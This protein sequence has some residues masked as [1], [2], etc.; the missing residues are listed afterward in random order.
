MEE[1]SVSLAECF[2][3]DDIKDYLVDFSNLRYSF[4]PRETN[5]IAH[6]LARYA[7][8]VDDYVVWLYI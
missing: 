6:E 8:V 5:Q 2:L 4:S 1:T 7:L 3:I